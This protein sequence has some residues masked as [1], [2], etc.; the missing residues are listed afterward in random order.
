M[1]YSFDAK[2]I[3]QISNILAVEAEFVDNCYTWLAK[4]QDN[5]ATFYVKI[6]VNIPPDNTTTI[7]IHTVLGTFEL[8]NVVCWQHF[9]ENEIVFYAD[10]D[11][12]LSCIF[13]S[14]DSGISVF[15]NINKNIFEKDISEVEPALLLAAMQLNLYNHNKDKQ[16]ISEKK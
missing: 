4:T 13:I 14:V 9:L 15:S 5:K 7:S 1:N 11:S 2:S 8:H 3:K 10:N 12:L 6:Y 16:Q